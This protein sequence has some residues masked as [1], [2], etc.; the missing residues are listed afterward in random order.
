ME[1]T[2]IKNFSQKKIFFKK[3]FFVMLFSLLFIPKVFAITYETPIGV[4]DN[5]VIPA[6]VNEIPDNT[7]Y[8]NSIVSGLVLKNPNSNY[9]NIL[10]NASYQTQL[11]ILPISENSQVQT[12]FEV[13]SSAF[14]G[15]IEDLPSDNSS[16]VS[17]SLFGEYCRSFS[18]VHYNY[19]D[20]NNPNYRLFSLPTPSDTSYFIYARL[21]A[22]DYYASPLD[23][24]FII[25]DNTNL[26]ET[27]S[28]SLFVSATSSTD[29]I[30]NVVPTQ[31]YN[32]PNTY[33][34]FL[35]KTP[36]AV[37]STNITSYWT[38]SYLSQNSLNAID[39]APTLNSS[40]TLPTYYGPI[41]DYVPPSSTD[42]FNFFST[43]TLPI[44]ATTTLDYQIEYRD[45]SATEIG[46]CIYN[47]GIGI[48]GAL[49]L[50]R[51]W[52]YSEIIQNSGITSKVPF[53]VVVAFRNLETQIKAID[54]GQVYSEI[55]YK[56]VIVI[57][58]IC[59]YDYFSPYCSNFYSVFRF[60]LWA[61][62]MVYL[63][64][65]LEYFF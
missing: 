60:L 63:Y 9:I 10:A 54:L 36:F 51:Y 56:D 50:P 12:D 6:V 1:K 35:F 13:S 52:N 15:I 14:T 18:D 37:N 27:M 49:A 42:F 5:F 19:F 57:K 17:S 62:F 31:Q 33:V 26:L 58:P 65:K 61:V 25:R 46:N 38:T 11:C 16:V 47:A 7:Y 64:R 44:T 3:V 24:D 23:L 2:F 45:C 22:G 29:F 21:I 59:E 8:L 43:S 55:N 53:T 48:F 30:Y 40:S 20:P 32:I 34:P 39:I 28:Y 41:Y 4:M